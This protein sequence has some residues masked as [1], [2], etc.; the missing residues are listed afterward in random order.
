[1]A[2]QKLLEW[3]NKAIA[4]E[5]QVSIQYMWQHVQWS[6]V[7]HFAVHDELKSVAIEEM[8]HAEK[9]AERLWYLGGVPTTKPTTISVGGD[10]WEMVDNDIK[11]ELEAIEM[12]KEIEK[13]ADD[14]DDPTTRFIFEQIL[15]Q[16]EEH[17]DLF[18]S[19]KEGKT[20]RKRQQPRGG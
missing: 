19:L 11:A 17:H 9:I 3:L 20:P 1:M 13:M 15:E 7:E 16:E 5:L 10:L 8:K 18:I 4:R 14:E 6:G 2:S 12:Y